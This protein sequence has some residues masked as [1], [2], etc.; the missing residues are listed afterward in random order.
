MAQYKHR[1]TG[2]VT[3]GGQVRKLNSNVSFSKV[4]DTFADLGWD[5]IGQTVKPEPSSPVKRIE[6]DGESIVAGK[7]IQKWAEVDMFADTT[8]DGVTTTKAEHE[9]AYK[10]GLEADKAAAERTKR[11]SLL[12]A[13]DW[14]ALSDITMTA[15]MTTYRQA[16]RDVPAQVGFPSAIDWP[17]SP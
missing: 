17:T 7:P 11:D 4:V 5:I 13:T 14:Q 16:L 6:R 15:E 3:T 1:D 10:A 12:A 9:A 8:E 2:E